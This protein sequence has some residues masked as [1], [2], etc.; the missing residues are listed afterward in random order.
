[1]KWS[2]SDHQ[3]MSRAMQ[4]ARLGFYSCQPN[5]RVGCV[6]VKNDSIVGEGCHLQ[7]GKDHAEVA[8]LKQAG[9]KATG[10]V[11]YVTLE[12]CVHTGRTPPCTEAL[13]KSGV[14]KVVAAMVDPDPRVAGEGFEK[15]NESGIETVSGLMKEQAMDLNRGYCKRMQRGVPWVR[16]KIAMSMDGKTALSSGQSKWITGKKARQDVQRL[17]AGSCAVI[18]GIGTILADDPA[19]NVRNVNTL[20]RQPVRVIIDRQ[21]RTPVDAK[22]FNGEGKVRIYTNI[23]DKDYIS[24]VNSQ[25]VQLTCLEAGSGFLES[26]IKSLADD[27]HVNDVLIEAGPGLSGAFM[28][29]GLIDELIIYQ[30]PVFLGDKARDALSIREILNLDDRIKLGLQE[31]RHM[32]DDVRYSFK[33][34]RE[35]IE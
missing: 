31:I 26:V 16:C 1:M 6:I 23:D 30:A 5:P 22:V 4:L 7:A 28:D 33:I 11:C 32:G 20:G 35:L 3:Y 24:S 15:L 12:P 17:R 2:I 21:L 27:E 19:L 25:S 14:T 9:D 29:S 8:A 13:I 10:A 34:L 18:T